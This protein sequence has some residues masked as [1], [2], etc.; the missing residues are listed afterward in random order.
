MGVVG[1]VFGSLLS[2]SVVLYAVVAAGEPSASSCVHEKL[3][4][5]TNETA[6]AF[7]QR[8]VDQGQRCV[9]A[10]DFDSAYRAFYAAY[11][12]D[13]STAHLWQLAL[14]QEATVGSS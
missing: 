2:L 1:R 10:N 13:P 8:Y 9:D 3:E 7:S 4:K 5:A 12:A 6:A 11:T 14:I